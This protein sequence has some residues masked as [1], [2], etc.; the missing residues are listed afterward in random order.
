MDKFD[1]F[2]IAGQSNSEG[3]GLGEVETPYVPN[4][5]IMQLEI[6]KTVVHSPEQLV[7][8]FIGEPILSIAEE[9]DSEN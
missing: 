8:D 3:C 1:V 4:S 9:L 5:R 2:I 6:K 7:I